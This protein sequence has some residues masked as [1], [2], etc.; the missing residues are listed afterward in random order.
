M[1]FLGIT[2][3]AMGLHGLVRG[4][5][6]CI[7]GQPLGH[8][9]LCATGYAVIQHPRGLANHQFCR[10]EPHF[11]LCQGKGDA[12]VFA[13]RPAKYHTLVGIA[14]RALQCRLA[15]AQGLSGD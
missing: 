13:N 15:N 5:K 10:V 11:G 1:I 9:G 4:L 3:A 2:E 6:T 7:S 8:V 14:H 12:L